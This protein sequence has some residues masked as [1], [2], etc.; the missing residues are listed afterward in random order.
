M[1]QS[2]INK[3]YKYMNI[4]Y[5]FLQRYLVPLYLVP[6]YLQIYIYI[7]YVS[8]FEINATYLQ[9]TEVLL[10]IILSRFLEFLSSK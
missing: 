2:L 9:I 4:I 6:L 10:N 7:E 5:I 3:I 1:T 8:P